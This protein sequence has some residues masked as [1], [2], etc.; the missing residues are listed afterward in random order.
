MIHSKFT[1]IFRAQ[2]SFKDWKGN[3]PLVCVYREGCLNRHYHLLRFERRSMD[4]LLVNKLRV[5]PIFIILKK[6]NKT[7]KL[8]LIILLVLNSWIKYLYCYVAVLLWEC[9]S[10]YVLWTVCVCICMFI[11]W[12]NTYLVYYLLCICANSFIAYSYLS[13]GKTRT[14]LF[15]YIY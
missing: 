1:V 6:Y 7:E 13:N 3:L 12:W 5:L 10:I 8:W 11:V 15:I 4:R 2:I 14:Y 9:I